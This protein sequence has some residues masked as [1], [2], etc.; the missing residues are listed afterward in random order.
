MNLEGS[1]WHLCSTSHGSANCIW[2]IW[3]WSMRISGNE[4]LTGCIPSEWETIED[5]DF[6][7]T[8]LP[9]CPGAPDPGVN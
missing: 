6:S 4:D 5:N 1:A 9:F 8:G 7:Q 2:E 3:L